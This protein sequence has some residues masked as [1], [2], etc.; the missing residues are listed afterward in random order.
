MADIIE[1]EEPLRHLVE[2]F[3]GFMEAER[4]FLIF[5]E[6]GQHDFRVC[7][8]RRGDSIERPW[9]QVSSGVID[10][11]I[12]AGRAILVRNAKKDPSFRN[13]PSITR[14]DLLSVLCAPLL[15]PRKGILGVIYLD[16]RSSAARFSQDDQD[17]LDILANQASL[18]MENARLAEELEGAKSRA[19]H[20]EGLET[21]LQAALRVSHHIKGTITK[22]IGRTR[23]IGLEQGPDLRDEQVTGTEEDALAGL[24]LLG[25]LEAITNPGPIA[26]PQAVGLRGIVEAC[27]SELPGGG[28]SR[29]V[30]IDPEVRAAGDQRQLVAAFR[31]VLWNAWHATQGATDGAIEV[32]AE[33]EG[34]EIH[35]TVTD[36]G[37]GLTEETV[38]RAQQTSSTADPGMV[39]LGL[40][41][42][43]A[44]VHNHGGTL[45]LEAAA[46]GGTVVH[47]R[48]PKP[49]E[50]NEP[51]A[52][53]DTQARTS[54]KILLVC[55]EVQV[56]EILAGSLA[57][58]G[59]AVQVAPSPEEGI[60]ALRREPSEVVMLDVGFPRDQID[61][62]IRA[63]GTVDPRPTVVVLAA[64]VDGRNAST[65][66][67]ADIVAHK[68]IQLR[69]LPQLV[70]RALADFE[71]RRG[72]ALC[73]PQ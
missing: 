7:K 1:V 51:A 10:E 39:G 49:E 59:N 4:G 32:G 18:A 55:D 66:E 53:V 13:R 25:K 48:L 26:R 56:G 70:Q 36:T 34:S 27:M 9:D 35:L 63:A 71:T 30:G 15:G 12:R 2:Q 20:A 52:F 14:L 16:N 19:A 22:I 44:V 38:S 67:G 42:A 23:V 21:R 47:I 61:G 62:L 57:G 41:V 60:E 65:V 24:R 8:D 54:G 69:L 50:G 72:A 40:C 33:A 45:D 28:P 6:E 43:N 31:E 17:M 68:P 46:G 37:P 29:S 73:A 58:Q 11:A 5:V 64:W 3:V